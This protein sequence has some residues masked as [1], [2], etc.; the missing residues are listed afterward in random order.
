MAILS[1]IRDRSM[2][3][4]LIVGLALFSFVLNPKSIQEFFSSSKINSVGEVN[5][6]SIDREEFVS[7]VE[8]YKSQRGRGATQMQAVNT[9]WNSLVSE[10]IFLSQLEKAGIV[11]GEKDIWDAMVNLPEIQNSPLFKNEANLFDEEKLKEYIANMKDDAEAGN[12][13]AWLSWLATEK[14]IKQNLERQAYTSLVTAGLGASLKEGERDYFFTNTKM[15]AQFVFVPYSKIPDS[16][17]RVTKEDVQN[18]IEKNPKRF[19]AEATRSLKYVKFDILPSKEDE[20]EIKKEVAKYIDDREEYSN[21][22][23]STVTVPGFKNATDYKQ[24]L[25]DNGSDLGFDDTYKYKNELPTELAEALFDGNVG[26]I[27]GPYK[28][29]GYFKLSKLVEVVQLPDSVKSSHIIVPYAGAQRSTSTKTKEEAKKIIDSI[30]TLVKNDTKKFEEIANEINSDGTKGKGG[31]IGWVRKNQAF[32]PSFDRDFANFIYKNKEGSIGIVETGFGY[33]IIRVD[34]QTAP[35]KAVKIATF[36]RLIEASEATEQHIYEKYQTLAASLDEGKLLEDVAK[37]NNYKIQS[38]LNL[39]ELDENV[40]GLGAQRPIVKWAFEEDR[41]VGDFK[42]FDVEYQGKRGY[43]V[44]VLTEKTDKDKLT[45]STD[46]LIRVR[47][48][49]MNKKKAAL[50]KKKLKGGTLAEIAKN[51]NETV[52][53]ASMVTLA[54]PLLPGVGNEPAVVG[55]MSAIKLNQVSDAIEGEKGVF[56]IKVT[57]REEPVKLDNYDNFRKRIVTQLQGRTY[58]LNQVLRESADIVDNRAKFN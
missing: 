14:Q 27:Y 20:E 18:Y 52:R 8:A 30:Y 6:E 22:T 3:L 17:V 36:A 28:D 31:E 48:E 47:P 44:A 11:V 7:E 53:T 5:G 29:K 46:I 9:V 45:V 50:L 15:D 51:N 42:G 55:A 12:T 56:V 4:I 43:V 19:K 34:E 24:F 10:K 40:P 13:Q 25:D 23:K 58:L 16:L 49:L 2:F 38:A 21:A 35:V 32:S 26:D 41:N 57:K 39:K 37:E 54:S 33:H 1:K